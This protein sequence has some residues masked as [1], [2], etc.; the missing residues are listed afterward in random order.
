ML[1]SLNNNN[2]R[3]ILVPLQEGG[4]KLNIKAASVLVRAFKLKNMPGYIFILSA[5]V[6]F[7]KLKTK[8]LAYTFQMKSAVC[9]KIIGELGEFQPWS[10]HFCSLSFAF[11]HCLLG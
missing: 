9:K 3:S 6:G 4:K 1:Q 5:G 2:V 11:Q 10:Q 8:S 7:T